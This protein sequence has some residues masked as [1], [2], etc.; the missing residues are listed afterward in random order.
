MF[1]TFIITSKMSCPYHN[2]LWL[3]QS[4][5]PINHVPI[6]HLAVC[7]KFSDV[8]G[9]TV[10]LW[11]WYALRGSFTFLLVIIFLL[12]H[13]AI[14]SKFISKR[15]WHTN[16]L[17]NYN[18]ILHYYYYYYI[19]NYTIFRNSCAWKES[20][21]GQNTSDSMLALELPKHIPAK[22]TQKSPNTYKHT[23]SPVSKWSVSLC[24]WW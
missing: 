17:A 20:M 1:Y 8:E 4:L 10:L 21:N 13:S 16:T 6:I 5:N 3:I 18:I 22:V 24:V 9:G 11:L 19:S 12:E 14:W 2:H 7:V 23:P 15:L